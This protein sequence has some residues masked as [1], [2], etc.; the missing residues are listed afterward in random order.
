VRRKPKFFLFGWPD[1]YTP[2]ATSEKLMGGTMGG[3]AWKPG[4]ASASL[5]PDMARG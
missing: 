5:A 1:R 2:G 3:S 4:C